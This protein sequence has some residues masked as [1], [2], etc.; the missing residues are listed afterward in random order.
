MVDS[1]NGKVCKMG[2]KLMIN[3]PVNHHKNFK[4][5]QKVKIKKIKN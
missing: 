4:R 1:F 3:V 5:G 2:R